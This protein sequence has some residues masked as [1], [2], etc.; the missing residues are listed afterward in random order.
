MDYAKR[1]PGSGR[2]GPPRAKVLNVVRVSSGNFLEMFDLIHITNNKAMPGV[3]MSAAALV[4][5]V[6][7]L[8]VGG[9]R[10]APNSV[11]LARSV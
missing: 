9:R 7:A 1:R 10:M 6:A 3:W 4:G 8:L 11:G 2:P 5:L